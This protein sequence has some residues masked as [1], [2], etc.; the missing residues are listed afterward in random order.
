MYT[1]SCYFIARLCKAKHVHV[2][3]IIIIILGS[4]ALYGPGPPLVEVT[5]SCAFMAVG[6]RPV[7]RA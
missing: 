3:I 2:N 5:K 6:D 7:S 4:T 1:P